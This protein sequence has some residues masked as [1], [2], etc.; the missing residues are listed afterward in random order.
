MSKLHS[1]LVLLLSGMAASSAHAAPLPVVQPYGPPAVLFDP[2]RDGCDG[3]DVPDAPSRLFRNADGDIVLFGLHYTN[4]FL[5]GRSLD[6]LKVVVP[7]R[8]VVER[9]CRPGRV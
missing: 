9:Q 2:S 8:L 3:N 1:L 4:H 5:R 6:T 7:L